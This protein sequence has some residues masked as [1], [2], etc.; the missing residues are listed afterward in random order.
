MRV[1]E[2]GVRCRPRQTDVAGHGWSPIGKSGSSCAGGTATGH[3]KIAGP[4]RRTR[5]SSGDCGAA[6][7]A[8]AGTRPD[9]QFHRSS[10]II[11]DGSTMVRTTSAST[12][13]ATSKP[14]AELV[15]LDHA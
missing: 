4:E 15:H 8:P 3:R 5:T 13:T 10:S 12:S 6:G 9:H 11:G 1:V 2:A 7:A 14:D